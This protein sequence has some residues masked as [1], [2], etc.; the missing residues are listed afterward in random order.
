LVKDSLTKVP[1]VQ[2]ATVFVR[3]DKGLRR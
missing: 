3:E 1:G 2:E